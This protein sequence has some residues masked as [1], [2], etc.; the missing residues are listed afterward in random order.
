MSTMSKIIYDKATGNMYA[1]LVIQYRT[2]KLIPIR[3]FSGFSRAGRT[4]TNDEWHDKHY[5]LFRLA[6]PSLTTTDWADDTTG[7]TW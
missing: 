3:H 1:L 6:K 4:D 7:W 2:L 5:V